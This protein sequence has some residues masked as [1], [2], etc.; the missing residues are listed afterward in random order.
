MEIM[1]ICL[2]TQRIFC[3][4]SCVHFANSKIYV[5]QNIDRSL[6]FGELWNEKKTAFYDDSI[7]IFSDFFSLLDQNIIK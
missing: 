1:M 2:S 4:Y 7:L 6:L 3:D 5:E